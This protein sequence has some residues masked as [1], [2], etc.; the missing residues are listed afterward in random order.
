MPPHEITEVDAHTLEA[1]FTSSSGHTTLRVTFDPTKGTAALVC[2]QDGRRVLTH[3]VPREAEPEPAP[4]SLEAW[5]RTG[6]PDSSVAMGGMPMSMR[7]DRRR[8]G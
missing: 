3:D 2:D 5:G 4:G 6:A 8:R 1:V 7:R